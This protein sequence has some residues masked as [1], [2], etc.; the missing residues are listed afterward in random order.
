MKTTYQY[1]FYPNTNQKSELNHWLRICRY[2]YNRQL[3]DR[4][5]WW[6]M[7]RT[8]IDA[9]PLITSISQP[10]EKPNYYNQ[11][12]LLPFIK[13]DLVKVFYSGELL[14]FKQV[15]STVLQ[16]VSKRVDKAFERFIVGDSK[17]G[18]SGRPRF[19]TE[20]DYRTMTFATA[21][22]DWIKLVRNDWLYIRLPKLGVIK[23]RMHR[24][25]PDGFTIKQASVTKKADGWFIQLILE[26]TSVP[27]LGSLHG[28]TL[29]F[30]QKETRPHELRNFTPDE[31][32]PNWDNSMGLDAVLHADVYLATSEGE[33]LPSLKPLRKNQTKLDRISTKRNKRKRGSKSR[34]KLAKKEAK[35][36]QRIARSRQDFQYKTAHKLV[37][38]CAKFFFYEDLNLKGLTKRN[39]I[40]QD[41]DGTYLPNGQSAKSGLNKSW[42]DA[43]FGQFFK[44]LDY[45]AA[46]AGAVVISKKPAYTSMVLSYR[47]EIIFTDCS[48]RDYWDE[49]NSLMVDR[50][51]NAAINLK[52]LGLDIF[53]SIK[54][55]SGNLSVVGTMDNSTVKEILHT[56]NRAAKMPTS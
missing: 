11:K 55:R 29:R 54:R 41:D 3:G 39:K 40:K 22:D 23:I 50:D 44:T 17:G 52:R 1:Q 14:D 20:A 35:Q 53:P 46:K 56:L 27:C 31:I 32:I 47:N 34:R 30:P 51:I 7:N 25:I 2:W 48:I 6:D 19:K 37:R 38:T 18:K 24:S 5:D 4:F 8:G 16:D 36:H 43:A 45:I 33:K 49:Q 13:K 10:R 26:D 9:C 15:D 12:A 21:S 28:R 42:L